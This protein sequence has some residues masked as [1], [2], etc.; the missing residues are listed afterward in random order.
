MGYAVIAEPI[1]LRG[2]GMSDRSDK[3]D[4]SDVRAV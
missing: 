4:G 1:F 3:A 2:G